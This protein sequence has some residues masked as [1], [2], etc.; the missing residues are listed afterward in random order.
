MGAM[1]I[2]FAIGTLWAFK[3]RGVPAGLRGLAVTLL[4]VAAWLTGTLEMLTE[5]T[6][7]VLDWAT[8][9]VFD[10]RVWAGV[11]LFGTAALLWLIAGRMRTSAVAKARGA[12]KQSANQ[13]PLNQAGANIPAT[14]AQLPP[15]TRSPGA[16]GS[17]S[18]GEPLLADPDL[19]DVEDILRRRGIS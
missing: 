10:P 14:G 11:G 17:A 19:A 6:G 5:I 13:A 1:T 15:A 12:R 7:A 2:L 18:G 9:L 8:G 4:P 16:S 3:S